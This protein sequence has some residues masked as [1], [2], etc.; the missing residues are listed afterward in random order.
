MY[1]FSCNWNKRFFRGV[2]QK[3]QADN[4]IVQTVYTSDPAPM[5]YNDTCYVYTGHDADGSTYFT[6]PDWKCYSSTDMQNWT[7]LGTV[8]SCD[9]FAW[10]E[11]DSA[12]AAQCVERNGKFY[13]FV[14][15]VPSEGG[16]RAIGVAVADSPEGTF[17]DALGKPLA[18]PNWD[19][20][21]PTVFID[22]GRSL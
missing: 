19:Y 8:L 4:L 20:I 16:G 3:A 11:A 22:D 21:D 10:A 15:L 5:V 18:G 17:K 2:P 14:T 9:D 6:M 13:M 7:N 12:W 1:N